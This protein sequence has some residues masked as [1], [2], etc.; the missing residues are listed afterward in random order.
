MTGQL[1]GR[2]AVVTGAGSG[3][4]RASA[5]RLAAEGATLLVNDLA[6]ERVTETVSMI[7]AVGGR[8]EGH[9]G[10][11]TD[12][13]FVDALVAAASDRHGRLDVFHS[14]AGAGL[15]QGSLL[16]VSDQGW[17]ADLQ[18]NLTSHLYCMRAAARAMSAAGGSIVITSSASATGAVANITPYGTAKAALLQLVKYASLEFGPHNIRVNAV[19]PG[20]VKTPAFME[21]MGTEERLHAYESQIPI[22]RACRPQDIA[23]AVLWLASDESDCVTGIGLIIDGGVSAVR[24][25][26]RIG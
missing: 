8:A 24:A 15:A 2:V 9:P 23:N 11:V 16:N 22:G 4:G 1:D 20:A 17:A 18:L 19:V 12:S 7:E 13:A 25:E 10:N 5:M 26:P 3:I 14:N 6:E 21:Y